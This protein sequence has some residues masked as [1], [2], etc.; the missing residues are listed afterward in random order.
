MYELDSARKSLT[1]EE[2][3]WIEGYLINFGFL[4]S[5]LINYE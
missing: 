4:N 5:S 1:K 2:K 3:K